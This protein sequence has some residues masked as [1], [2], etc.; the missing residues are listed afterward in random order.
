MILF[1]CL[2]LVV[3]A[4]AYFKRTYFTLR[5]GIPGLA[6]QFFLGNL[7]QTDLLTNR[8]SLVEVFVDLKAKFGD[9]YQLWLGPAHYIVVNDINDVQHIF[10]DRNIY[11]Q[12]DIF[13]EQVRVLF[14]DGLI[15]LKGTLD[16]QDSVFINH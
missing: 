14:P 2:V 8:K 6:P 13:I 1:L 11:D 4:Y 3:C 15:C 7:W 12:G 9:I 16:P 10:N 5:P